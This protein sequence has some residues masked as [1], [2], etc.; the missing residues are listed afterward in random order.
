MKVADIRLGWKKSVSIGVLSQLLTLTV[1]GVTTTAALDANI[2]EFMIVVSASKSVQFKVDTTDIDGTT[3]SLVYDFL[4][5]DLE[6]P[7][8]ATDLFHQVVAI[9]DIPD[10]PVV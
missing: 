5:S 6:L 7:L 1:D 2:E 3:S 4:V 9:R 8:P 10:E